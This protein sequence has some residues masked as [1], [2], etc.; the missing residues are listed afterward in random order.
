MGFLSDPTGD[1]TGAGCLY[2]GGIIVAVILTLWA[3]VALFSLSFIAT[4]AL[5]CLAFAGGVLTL[6]LVGS[7]INRIGNPY[8]KW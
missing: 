8:D 7:F 1:N 4:I 6:Y 2:A 3:G 5:L